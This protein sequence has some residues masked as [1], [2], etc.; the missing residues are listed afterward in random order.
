MPLPAPTT[1]PRHRHVAGR[2][3]LLD[4]FLPVWIFA[5]MA[6]GIGLGR[7]FPGIAPMLNAL[8]VAHVSLPIALGLLWMMYPV[9]ARVKYEQLPAIAGNWKFL[10]TSLVLNWLLGP[11][12]MFAIAWLLLPDEP[13]FRTG[14]ILVGLARCIAMVLIWNLLA[15]GNNEYAAVLVAFN[16]VF[17]ML[18]YAVFAYFYLTVVPG[19][20]GAGGTV[21]HVSI[22]DVAKSVLIFLGIPLAAGFLTRYFLGRSK[23]RAWYETRFLPRLAPLALIGLLFTIVMMFSLKGEVIVALPL[24]VVRIG[25]P[26]L[27]YFGVMFTLAFGV[28]YLLRFPY[29]E[30]A[31]LS[32]TAASNDFEL[33]IAVAIGVFG[34]ASGQALAAVVGPLVEVPVLLG[35]V[36]VSLWLRRTLYHQQN[37]QA[38][39]GDDLAHAGAQGAP[40]EE[41]TGLE[42]R[43]QRVLFIDPQN[44]ARSHMAAGWLRALAGDRYEVQ[45]AGTQATNRCPLAIQAMAEVGV[46]LSSQPSTMLDA[47]AS[48]PW[49]WVITVCDNAHE[50]CPHFPGGCHQLQWPVLDLREAR[51]SA[52]QQLAVYRQIRDDLRAR[53]EAFLA[54]AAHTQLVG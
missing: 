20:L 39:Q 52:A 38:M 9:L 1:T 17:Q 16:A 34:I 25:V 27:V 12:L 3:P 18:M 11:A 19:W 21:Q 43:K 37:G 40:E 35:L 23:G 47:H 14:L 29:A 49:D 33:A 5:A 15:R 54:P 10:L 32:F 24:A 8:Q 51:G 2:L 28:S 13:A 42:A 53:I 31:T 46:D 22:G 41:G 4:R 30:A 44:A 36:Y 7:L 6:L 45:S 50:A 26:L 48:Q